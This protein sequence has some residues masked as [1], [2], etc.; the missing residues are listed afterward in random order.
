MSLIKK[1][2]RGNSVTWEYGDPLAINL[3]KP[4]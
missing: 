4:Q 1:L 2:D 3:C